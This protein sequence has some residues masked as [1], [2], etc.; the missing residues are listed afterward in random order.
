MAAPS[1]ITMR[2]TPVPAMSAL[3]SERP[4]SGGPRDRPSCAPGGSNAT[5]LRQRRLAQILRGLTTVLQV[6]E[7]R[8][9]LVR[10]ERHGDEPRLDALANRAGLR[11][12]LV[13]PEPLRRI[14]EADRLEKRHAEIIIGAQ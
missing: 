3:Q 4:L 1:R 8:S 5:Q 10:F 12:V 6:S 11:K 7:G 2:T 14:P 9:G 13:G